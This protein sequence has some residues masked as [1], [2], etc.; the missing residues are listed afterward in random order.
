LFVFWYYF[1]FVDRTTAATANE[2]EGTL[3][4]TKE[5]KTKTRRE[6][7]EDEA[8]GNRI[9]G[10]C[11]SNRVPDRQVNKNEWET[12]ITRG[13]DI[14][15]RLEKEEQYPFFLYLSEV[16]S[17]DTEER[18]KSDRRSKRDRCT[19][20]KYFVDETN[21]GVIVGQCNRRAGFQRWNVSDGV[22]RM[23][24]DRPRQGTR[25]LLYYDVV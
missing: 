10:C 11:G 1:S 5:K 24:N 9:S 20:T 6:R 12:T 19:R 14:F 22:R 15:W 3:E 4:T 13:V 25:V 16:I 17:I 7:T 21:G 8:N 23:R 2:D 18:S